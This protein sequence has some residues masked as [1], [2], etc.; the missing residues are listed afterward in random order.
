MRKRSPPGSMADSRGRLSPRQSAI[1]LDARGARRCWRRWHVSRR[2]SRRRVLG[3]EA[4]PSGGS[5]RLPRRRRRWRC[6]SRSTVNGARP[7]FPRHQPRCRALLSR[8]GRLRCRPIS[9]RVSRRFRL[10]MRRSPQQKLLGRPIPLHDAS[11]RLHSPEGAGE[12]AGDKP[13]TRVAQPCRHAPT[14][15]RQLPRKPPRRPLRLRLRHPRRLHPPRGPLRGMPLRRR[16]LT[17]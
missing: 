15:Q 2:Q 11:R 12:V 4:R 9:S 14:R 10:R 6:G 17:L 7:L 8:A 3:G 5:R 1:R 16:W 13:R